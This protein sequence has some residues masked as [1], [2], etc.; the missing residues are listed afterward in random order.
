[1]TVRLYRSIARLIRMDK[2]NNTG[3]LIKVPPIKIKPKILNLCSPKELRH[4][5]VMLEFFFCRNLSVHFW[6]T[7]P[8][9]K[10]AVWQP[11]FAKYP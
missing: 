10:K 2:R 3:M 4:D 9:I 6:G 8:T 7:K 11:Y 1:M 5:M